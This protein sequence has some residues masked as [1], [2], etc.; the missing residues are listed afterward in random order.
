[1]RLNAPFALWTEKKRVDGALGRWL[2]RLRDLVTR[3]ASQV[4]QIERIVEVLRQVENV[5]S[6]R[7]AACELF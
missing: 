1:M 7:N 2:V 6:P 5:A 4:G 3:N